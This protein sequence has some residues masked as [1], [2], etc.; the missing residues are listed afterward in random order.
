MKAVGIKGGKGSSDDF[1]IEDNVPDPVANGNRILVRIHSFGLNR[2]DIMQRED[3]YPYPLLPESGKILGVEFS[4]IV[5][6][7]GAECMPLSPCLEAYFASFGILTFSRPVGF[8]SWTKMLWPCLWRCR[9]WPIKDPTCQLMQQA[10]VLP[11]IQYAE[12]I[13][14]SEN[15]LMHMPEGM[16]FE[17]AAGFPEVS[18]FP[19]TLRSSSC[20]F[21]SKLTLRRLTSLPSKQCTSLVAWNLVSQS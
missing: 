19:L 12:K 7:M 16:S 15:M 4:G 21:G 1:F 9:E 17:T 13:S 5:E 2:M 11:H 14:V 20:K 18:S 10:N 3:R 8:P 6:A